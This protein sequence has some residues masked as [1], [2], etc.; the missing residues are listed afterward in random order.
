MVH[1]RVFNNGITSDKVF[2]IWFF[3]SMKWY[4]FESN[5]EIQKQEK[6]QFWNKTTAVLCLVTIAPNVHSLCV[7][8]CPL[9]CDRSP[10]ARDQWLRWPPRLVFAC[11]HQ[12]I[13]ITASYLH[14][15]PQV[16]HNHNSQSQS[17]TGICGMIVNDLWDIDI[18][19]V[20]HVM[21]H[22]YQY[23]SISVHIILHN[24]IYWEP[25]VL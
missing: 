1:P 25:P 21:W 10:R 15:S 4:L 22:F 16:S 11:L 13:I 12:Y 7:Q 14:I 17:W 8:L 6:F 20:P 24:Y 5:D 2:Q 18:M 23:L 9:W 19:S 3:L